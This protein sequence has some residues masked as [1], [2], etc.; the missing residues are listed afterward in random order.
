LAVFGV[1]NPNIRNTHG[2]I[3]VDADF[4]PAHPILGRKDF[5]AEKGRRGGDSF[6]RVRE[7]DAEIR[8]ADPAGSYAKAEFR[9]HAHAERL[10][11]A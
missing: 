7:E 3:I 2:E 9:D 5:D 8:E 1:K 10:V 6:V 11:I 4:D